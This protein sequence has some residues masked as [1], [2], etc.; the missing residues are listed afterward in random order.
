MD[1]MCPRLLRSH[2]YRCP[3]VTC[4]CLLEW[5]LID[6]DLIPARFDVLLFSAGTA[7]IMHAYSGDQGRHRDV[8]KSKYLN[9]LDF[10]FGN[11]GVQAGSIAH[12]PGNRELIKTAATRVIRSISKGDFLSPQHQG[13]GTRSS[14]P[15][16]HHRSLQASSSHL[17][18]AP[19]SH[20][21][22]ALAGGAS[23][24]AASVAVPASSPGFTRRSLEDHRS[25]MVSSVPIPIPIHRGS[26]S[27][28]TDHSREPAFA[29]RLVISSYMPASEKE[30]N[31]LSRDR[32]QHG[33]SGALQMMDRSQ[34]AALTSA[35]NDVLL[36]SGS[37]PAIS[38]LLSKAFRERAHGSSNALHTLQ[39]GK[40]NG[41]SQ[42][43]QQE[44]DVFGGFPVSRF[45]AS[46][47]QPAH[48]RGEQQI[49][50]TTPSLE[51]VPSPATRG[52]SEGKSAE[53]EVRIVRR[54]VTAPACES[55]PI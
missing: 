17:L 16:H 18:H 35:S 28:L 38:G 24:S 8:F 30:P 33:G 3:L 25:R 42:A 46:G 54:S 20:L 52:A 41:Q 12:L 19:S 4:R 21:P 44:R 7:A 47:W 13:D 43:S 15:I 10:I 23:S 9:V 22:H 48:Q 5:G 49:R 40:A 26:G 50:P 2:S 27:H 34:S 45:Q 37:L 11:V 29:T 14:V 6:P 55:E 32:T 1:V 39:T 36:K 31:T 53:L 51:P